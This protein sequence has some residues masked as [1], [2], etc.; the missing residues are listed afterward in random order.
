MSFFYLHKIQ[1][2][3][4]VGMTDA[5]RKQRT[6]LAK[7]LLKKLAELFPEKKTELDSGSPWELLVAVILSAQCTDS[8][9]NM[10]TEKLFKKYKKIQDY[11]GANI[12][13]FESDIYST[14]FYR[15]KTK[16]IIGAAKKIIDDFAGQVPKTLEELITIPGAGRKTANVVSQNLWGIN[17][18][19]AVDTHVRR[20]AIRF[21]LTD[22]K[23]P[24]IIE[25]DLMEII[26]QSQWRNA[27][28]YMKQ[29]GREIAPAR[30]YDT[31]VD[32]LVK[33]YPPAGKIFRVK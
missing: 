14:G 21:G 19:F 29:Y 2:A 6:I 3:Y 8:R 17:H 22:S 7:K 12:S 1:Y 11:A 27:G 15:N 30:K 5:Q 13:E 28:Y 20:F 9:V 25:R 10:V 26:P 32:P 33:I 23:N 4:T 16:N 31:S 18:G 24:I